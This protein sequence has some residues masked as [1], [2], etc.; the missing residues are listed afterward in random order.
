MYNDLPASLNEFIRDVMAGPKESP[1]LPLDQLDMLVT[2]PNI[3]RELQLSGSIV[4]LQ[5]TALQVWSCKTLDNGSLTTRRKLFIILCLMEKP[6][7]I[8]VFIREDIF[9]ADL[10]FEFDQN[11]AVGR[12]GHPIR[13]FATWRRCDVDSFKNYQGQVTAPYFKLSN[14]RDPHFREYKLHP[15]VQLPF[16]AHE[17]KSSA[18]DNSDLESAIRREGGYSVVRKVRMHSAHHDHTKYPV[19]TS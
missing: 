14:D 6:G 12:S 4:D 9:D 7:D 18:L 19:R 5:A 3:R 15:C 10:P 2:V 17:L 11:Q 16:V 8:E 13:L 1:F